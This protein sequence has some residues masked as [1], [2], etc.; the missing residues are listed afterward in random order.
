MLQSSGLVEIPESIMDVFMVFACVLLLLKIMFD[1]TGAKRLLIKILVI[2]MVILLRTFGLPMPIVSSCFAFLAMEKVNI[3][4]VIKID[5][6]VKCAFFIFSAIVFGADYFTGQERVA[7]YIFEAKKGTAVALYF[8]NP[9]TTGLVGT[10][11]ALDLLYLKDNKKFRDFVFPTLIAVATFALT[12]SR[13]PFLVYCVYLL[14]Q[15][16]K[17]GKVLTIIQK[18]TYPVLFGF[19]F[20]VVN[21]VPVGSSMYR[22]LNPL[23][24][25]RIWY[26]IVAY[27]SAGLTILPSLANTILLKNYIIDIFYVRCIVRY[28]LITLL[29]YY[30]P[31]LMLPTNATNEQKR[32]SI[33]ASVYLFFED[34]VSNVGFAIPYLIIADAI[35]NKKEIPDGKNKK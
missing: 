6:L 4:T 27:N 7:E 5:L 10:M 13:A 23:L 9:N 8:K 18:L 17:N 24:S 19:T 2:L 14:L 1:K 20:Y 16:I 34:A 35:F 26:S 29:L 15:L 25:S 32:M 21:S 3:K 22:I 28:G 12:T 31:H 33:I 11:I 30:I